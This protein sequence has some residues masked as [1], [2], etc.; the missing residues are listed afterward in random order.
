MIRRPVSRPGVARLIFAS[1]LAVTGTVALSGL[2][3]GA[4][5]SLQGMRDAMRA[6]PATGRVALVE[7]D[8][9]S[10]ATLDRWPWPRGLYAQ[11]LAVLGRNG[12]RQVAFD[13]DL[14]SRSA[15]DQDAAFA[16]ALADTP[17]PVVLA[18]LRQAA[19]QGAAVERE[20]LPI[21]A[22]RSHAM[23]A[24]VNV[25][26][27]RD[28]LV[29]TYPYGAVTGGV[30]RPSIGAMLADATG[31]VGGSFPIDG[32]IDPASVPR[33]NFADLIAGRVPRA[34]IAGRALLIGAT[35]IELND[36][37]AVPRHGTLPGALLQLLAAET[38]LQGTAPFDHGSLPAM[39]LLAL[40][41][42][43][44][45]RAAARRRMALF[46]LAAVA[47]LLL[48]LL[49]ELLRWG[50]VEIVPALAGLGVAAGLAAAT[51]AARRAAAA[52]LVDPDTG[53]PNAR[54]L[55]AAGNGAVG[56]LRLANHGEVA[57]V[58]GQGAATELV[59]RLADR[60]GP[61]LGTP[62]YRAAD[63]ALAWTLPAAE[64]ERG[65][66]LAE[67]AAAQLAQPFE[68]A[69]RWVAGLGAAGLAA[70]PDAA[71][72]LDQALL[73]ADR[74]FARGVPWD[75][76]DADSAREHDWRLGLVHE[77]DRAMAA[78]EVWVAYQPKLDLRSDRITAAEALVRWR[79]P[80]R[81]PIPP[82]A[83]IP[84]LEASGRIADLTLFVLER[85][86]TD[87]AAWAAAGQP[88]GVA[89][90]ISALLPA[91]PA[92]MRRLEALL[93]RMP[94]GTAG[95][96]L[97]VTESAALA[98]AE[99]AIAALERLAALGIRLSID[100]Y[101]TG[102]ST[103]SYLKR[104]P[105]REIKIDKSFV[106]PL[107]TSR[108]D[109]AMVRSTVALAHELGFTVVAEG[110]ETPAAMALLIAY[111]CDTA[112]GWHIGRPVPAP[113]LLAAACGWGLAQAA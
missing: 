8:A 5:H 7:I 90:N 82:D 33:L 49:S 32:A 12:A 14:S 110:V 44:I 28:G 101:G 43:L 46:A 6:R 10:L 16:R 63:N 75:R 51:E 111:G 13:I 71:R 45:L 62:I 56:A 99:A 109:Q 4:E 93:A 112:Q 67:T 89:V 1:A 30:A 24:A 41:L 73:A 53:L 61:A 31:R 11:A 57:G 96:T 38:L 47:L 92:F 64:A 19:S 70:D 58:L 55:A 15:P 83:F 113:D 97:E 52:R 26:E 107:E 94:G 77:L 108:G 102:Q 72:A 42:P 3:A 65:G 78:G 106:Q 98:D 91:D 17:V 48:P 81:G 105:A 37:F 22:F 84:A 85:A 68:L 9:R 2:G 104:L 60:L 66:E 79:H 80:E 34:A 36:R 103:L 25:F 18:T 69:G 23:L 88:L 95:L 100:D 87:R 50:T 54:A 35:A 20:N 74:A 21:P 39:L 76:H 86:L 40:A 29:R 59:R 27:D